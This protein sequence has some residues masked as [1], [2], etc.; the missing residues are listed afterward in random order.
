MSPHWAAGPATDRRDRSPEVG[1]E[2]VGAM[3]TILRKK[4][5]RT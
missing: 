5:G 3:A 1:I 2:R 4:R